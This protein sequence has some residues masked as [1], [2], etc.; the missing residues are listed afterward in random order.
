MQVKTIDVVLTDEE[1]GLVDRLRALGFSSK[2]ELLRFAALAWVDGAAARRP[3]TPPPARRP[4]TSPQQALP[5]RD[6]MNLPVPLA[7]LALVACPSAQIDS[8]GGKAAVGSLT[9]HGSIGGIVAT[10]PAPLGSLSLR[11]GRIEILHATAPL[12]LDVW[13][14]Q[15]SVTPL[16]ICF[17]R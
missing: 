3:R 6:P 17:S 16:R 9:N 7:A 14:G 10:A 15:P 12:D 1:L 11:N 5:P 4:A 2:A 8:G 13:E